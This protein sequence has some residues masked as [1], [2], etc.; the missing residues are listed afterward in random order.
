MGLPL[1]H[2]AVVHVRLLH[3]RGVHHLLLQLLIVPFLLLQFEH[4]LLQ[5]YLRALERLEV[6]ANVH[7]LYCIAV[8]VLLVVRCWLVF[9]WFACL[10]CRR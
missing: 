10:P 8:K 9:G 7:L 1:R 3:S 2:A 4:D 5:P 6:F